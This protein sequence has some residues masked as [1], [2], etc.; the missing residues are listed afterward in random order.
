MN[1]TTR[2]RDRDLVGEI[3]RVGMEWEGPEPLN[4][5]RVIEKVLSGCTARFYVNYDTAYRYVSRALRN[6]GCL[7]DTGQRRG[8]W[9][10]M[11]RQVE[12]VWKSRPHLSYIDALSIVIENGVA[13]RF[14]LTH[15]SART[16]YFKNRRRQP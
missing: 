8:Q 2:E 9:V 1:D 6:R 11:A 13:P 12:I 4:I 10:D 14:Y 15:K 5:D 7:N 16:I 3:K